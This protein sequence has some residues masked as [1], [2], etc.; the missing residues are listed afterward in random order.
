MVFVQ[1]IQNFGANICEQSNTLHCKPIKFLILA[2]SLAME[3]QI[4][5]ERNT[6]YGLKFRTKS[7]FSLAESVDRSSLDA[8]LLYQ[9][10]TNVFLSILVLGLIGLN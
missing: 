8:L 10:F 5:Q 7:E 3:L 9:K 1:F 4:V 6:E 2:S